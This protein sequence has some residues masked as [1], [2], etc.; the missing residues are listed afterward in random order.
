MCCCINAAGTALPPAYIFPRVRFKSEM[1]RGAPAGS[2]GLANQ[3]EWM[4]ADIFSE[5]LL[6]FI[7]YMSVSKDQPGVLIFDNLSSHITLETIELARDH[8]LS[9]VTLPPHYSHKLQPL[10]V[11]VFGAFKRFYSS[12]CNDWHLSNPG[13]TITQFIMFRN[14]LVKPL[15]NL[16]QWKTFFRRSDALA[17]FL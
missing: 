17:Y 9:L 14:Y 12:I 8:G 5:V 11:G 1:L 16:S 15:Q 10:D 4:R 3:S 7:S 13:K 2:L 6:H